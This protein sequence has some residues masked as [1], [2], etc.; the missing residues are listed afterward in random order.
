MN[1]I[2][3][4]DDFNNLTKER[5][6]NDEN[7]WNADSVELDNS[8]KQELF[9]LHEI[10]WNDFMSLM[11]SPIN[12]FEITIQMKRNTWNQL[13]RLKT[14]VENSTNKLCKLKTNNT[15]KLDWINVKDFMYYFTTLLEKGTT[16]DI[17]SLVNNIG[18]SDFEYLKRITY[19][20]KSINK[21]GE[22]FGQLME[23]V[24]QDPSPFSYHKLDLHIRQQNYQ[25]IL[26]SYLN[27]SE[28]TIDSVVYDKLSKQLDDTLVFR[29]LS[30]MVTDNVNPR[31]LIPYALA[32][33]KLLKTYL[34]LANSNCVTVNGRKKKITLSQIVEIVERFEYQEDTRKVDL[35]KRIAVFIKVRKQHAIFYEHLNRLSRNHYF[36]EDRLELESFIEDLY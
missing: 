7:F 18:T 32:S 36:D 28:W 8:M 10:N 21:Q 4:L 31:R 14:M 34:R 11:K 20:V 1:I 29:R 22:F 12:Q 13:Y 26:I 9:G 24:L 16:D 2:Q 17:D 15:N 23:E 5:Q 27:Q 6:K 33:E 3:Y 35:L 19:T 30:T 25:D